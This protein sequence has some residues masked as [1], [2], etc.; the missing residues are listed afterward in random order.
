[1]S[2]M[3]AKVPKLSTLYKNNL[4][5]TV[6]IIVIGISMFIASNQ[7]LRITN[8]LTLIII[9][10]VILI[11]PLVYFLY[12][13]KTDLK[14]LGFN[15]IRVF[16]TVFSIICGFVIFILL[17]GLVHS[18]QEYF[19]ISTP[20][21]GVQKSYAPVFQDMSI[22]TIILIA[23]IIVPIVEELLF[24][25]LIF[26]QI[27]SSTTNKII[28]SSLIFALFHLQL[29][30]FIPLTILGLILGYLRI[31]QNSIY[32]PIIFHMLNNIFVIYVSFFLLST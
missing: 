31:S 15:K 7:L 1:M 19:N 10:Q 2:R 25:G 24:R 30:V 11:M 13:K 14:S 22:V 12:K 16:K 18:I 26:D 9:Q 27:K 17:S 23:G 21:Y 20:G 29:E 5:Q 32:V 4:I 6:T 3:Q 8:N 28:I